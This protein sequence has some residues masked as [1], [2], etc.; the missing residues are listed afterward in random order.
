M[1]ASS[2][3]EAQAEAT[4][5]EW[6]VYVLISDSAGCSYVGITTDLERRLQQHNGE[7]PGGARSTTRGRP[8][9]LGASYGPFEGRGEALRVEYEVKKRRGAARLSWSP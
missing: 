9:R 1:G 3:A 2:C 4:P 7:L 8:W 5:P 6:R